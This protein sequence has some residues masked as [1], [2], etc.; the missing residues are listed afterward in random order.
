M[1]L[2]HGEM[3]PGNR[4]L[5]SMISGSFKKILKHASDKASAQEK[6]SEDLTSYLPHSLYEPLVLR[7]ESFSKLRSTVLPSTE[8]LKKERRYYN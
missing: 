7:R 8:Y 2:I 1:M 3:R 5:M 6:I 4:S